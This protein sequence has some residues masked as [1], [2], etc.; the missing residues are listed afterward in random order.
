MRLRIPGSAAASAAGVAV[1]REAI[2]IG[3]GLFSWSPREWSIP[4]FA[5]TRIERRRA[6]AT[7][8]WMIHH[9][10]QDCPATIVLW[11]PRETWFGERMAAL[12]YRVTCA[13]REISRRTL[14]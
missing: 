13:A 8:G 1:S 3:I 12:G 10:A 14:R 4:S 2:G 5:V 7:G 6:E 9:A 11:E